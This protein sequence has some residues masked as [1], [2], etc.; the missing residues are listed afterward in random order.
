MA[1]WWPVAG[2]SSMTFLL[3]LAVLVVVGTGN[4]CECGPD[5]P[6]LAGG[7][8]F[9]LNGYKGSLATALPFCDHG[10]FVFS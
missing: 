6:Q 3:L 5:A 2:M 10:S 4:A 7:N 1:M 9:G 8:P